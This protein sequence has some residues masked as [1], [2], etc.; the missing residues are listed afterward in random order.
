MENYDVITFFEECMTILQYLYARSL[1]GNCPL[2][3]AAF[4]HRRSPVTFQTYHNAMI[5]I[6]LNIGYEIYG[7]NNVFKVDLCTL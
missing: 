7:K 1:A 3:A 5:G 4:C 2:L 6:F